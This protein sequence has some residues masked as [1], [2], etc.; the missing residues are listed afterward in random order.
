MSGQQETVNLDTLA[1]EQLAQVK[2]QLDEELEH[3][4][5]SFSQLHG[6]QNKFRD[7]LRTVQHRKNASAD[8]SNAVLVPLTNSLYVR[9]ELTNTERV[10]VDVGTGFL[11]EKDLASAE[12]F[13]DN[14]VSE[15]TNNLKDLETIVQRKQMNA[16]TIEEV[17]R[18]KIM[19]SQSQ[20][21]QGQG[22]QAQAA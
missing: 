1:P 8:S 17:L 22:A 14:K 6:A 11:V 18:Q 19:A 12:K 4:T 16:R 10:L 20:G 9:G 13:Y 2:K 21:G 7:C 15:L 5:Q 3:L